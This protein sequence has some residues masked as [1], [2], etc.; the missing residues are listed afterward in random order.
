MPARTQ[1]GSRRGVNPSS[2][3]DGARTVHLS[4]YDLRVR[5]SNLFSGADDRFEIFARRTKTRP[6]EPFFRR[7]RL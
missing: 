5:E 3:A 1:G 7:E 4:D 6:R 2:E